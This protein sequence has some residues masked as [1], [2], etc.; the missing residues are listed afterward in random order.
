M[1]LVEFLENHQKGGGGVVISNQK[2]IVI[3]F[4]YLRMFRE[5]L[6]HCTLT[7]GRVGRLVGEGGERPLGDS[8]DIYPILRRQAS[9][10]E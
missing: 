9:L 3:F 7:N 8:L 10:T 6:H 5:S 2:K 4:A 1:K